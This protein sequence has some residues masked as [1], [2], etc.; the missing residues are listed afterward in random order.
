MA[1]QPH[2]DPGLGGNLADRRALEAM[3]LEARQRRLDQVGLAQ[4]RFHAGKTGFLIHGDCSWIQSLGPALA[5]DELNDCTAR[6]GK[7]SSQS[8]KPRRLHRGQARSHRISVARG[9]CVQ[10]HTLWELA[11]QRFGHHSLSR[12]RINPDTPEPPDPT[13]ATTPPKPVASHPDR[14]TRLHPAA[15]PDH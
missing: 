13:T 12:I 2:R 8:G 3:T 10:P 14:S 6:A 7:I 1:D 4:L 11:C 9:F 5:S 15:A